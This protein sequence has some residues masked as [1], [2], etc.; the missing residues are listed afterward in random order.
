MES[1]RAPSAPSAGA[2][3]TRR[4]QVRRA[5]QA[6][7]ESPRLRCSWQLSTKDILEGGVELCGI[8]PPR[9]LDLGRPDLIAAL[10]VVQALV[11]D[12]AQ[13][14][15]ARVERVAAALPATHRSKPSH[16]S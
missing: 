14:R 15:P 12:R 16:C 8:I 4:P 11:A 5:L 9:Q 6:R 3:R 1:R 10:L 2:G 13:R 7:G